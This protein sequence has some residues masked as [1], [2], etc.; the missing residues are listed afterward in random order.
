MAAI[1]PLS[2]SSSSL[3]GVIPRS[4]STLN[5]SSEQKSITDT[6]DAVT[7][8]NSERE[9]RLG[10][11]KAVRALSDLQSFVDV[12]ADA[13]TRVDELLKSS[14]QITNKLEVEVDPIKRAALASEGAR[15]LSEVD[16]IASSAEAPNGQSVA[17]QG[18]I[19]YTL[20]LGKQEDGSK[21]S[22]SV[23]IPSVL[24]TRSSLG[25]DSVDEESLRTGPS[26]DR[27]K[28]E[29]ARSSLSNTSASLNSISSKISQVVDK[30][31]E[32]RA[33]SSDVL[34][35][36]EAESFADQLSSA[37]SKSE[38]IKGTNTALEPLAVSSLLNED[39]DEKKKGEEKLNSSSE[40]IGASSG[41]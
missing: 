11:A 28:L 7:V 21:N 3:T 26:A 25:I 4:N 1:R 13:T 18:Q 41:L 12:A 5:I 8:G 32:E 16:Q 36:K 20:S 39:N 10:V 17:S 30:Y 27:E 22:I 35:E 38:I 24:L 29:N 2:D 37:L 14:I 19:N 15:L 9:K 33:K 6:Q 31:G 34:S 23:T 40:R